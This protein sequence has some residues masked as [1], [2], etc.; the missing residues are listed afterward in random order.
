MLESR[1]FRFVAWAA[2]GLIATNFLAATVETIDHRK[3]QGE[4]FFKEPQSIVIQTNSGD[5]ATFSYHD[6][7]RVTFQ[8]SSPPVSAVSWQ[9]QDVGDVFTPGS[10]RLEQGSSTVLASGWGWWDT[11]DAFGFRK[12]QT[13]GDGELVAHL[14]GFHDSNGLVYAGITLRE[15]L[16]S[17]SPHAT[18][19]VS[20]TGKVRLKSRPATEGELV[21]TREGA[22]WLRLRRFRD[23][24]VAYTSTDGL[25]WEPVQEAPLRLGNQVYAGPVVATAINAFLGG[26]TF[27]TCEWIGADVPN[28]F[29][30]LPSHGVVLTD[31]S[32]VAGQPVIKGQSVVI[33]ERR[34]EQWQVPLGQVS[35]IL[36][37]PAAKSAVLQE[38]G[39]RPGV[40]TGGGDF[41][42][43][44]IAVVSTNSVTI[45]SVL[46]G[47][48][49][50]A[51]NSHPAAIVF[52]GISREPG[53]FDVRLKD[54]SIVRATDLVSM[55]NLIQVTNPLLGRIRVGLTDLRDVVFASPR[56]LNK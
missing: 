27:Q 50:I 47:L 15:T 12:T 40:L 11:S 19:I 39:G 24:V 36:L 22:S 51:L 26:A 13:T 53:R 42:E 48:K 2:P 45:D 46:F 56:Q 3:I 44:R 23:E 8:G 17:N 55:T 1:S 6:V 28:R 49:K 41:L 4:I 16:S 35:V 29:V 14:K 7:V 34:D 25:E 37:R 5:T 33:L 20:S 52:S 31:G 54:D 10:M 38:G 9:F 43:G 18:L 21:T 30:D 32:I